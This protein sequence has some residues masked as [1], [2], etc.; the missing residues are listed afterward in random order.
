MWF[1]TY[2]PDLREIG[3]AIWTLFYSLFHTRTYAAKAP[4]KGVMEFENVRIHK[5]THITYRFVIKIKRES[6][7]NIER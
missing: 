6:E 1:S 7:R 4:N 2:L 5:R 3:N